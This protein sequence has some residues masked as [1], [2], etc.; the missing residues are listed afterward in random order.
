MIY[1]IYMF[2]YILRLNAFGRV[3]SINAEMFHDL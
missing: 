3:G 1:K 2:S